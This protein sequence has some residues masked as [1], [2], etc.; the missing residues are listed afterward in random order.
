MD[1]RYGSVN[2]R[3]EGAIAPDP[4]VDRVVDSLVLQLERA[5]IVD[6]GADVLRVGEH[7]M[8]GRPCPLAPVLSVNAGAIE[9]LGD[10]AFS[11]IVRDKPSVDLL[12]YLD[13]RSG[14]GRRMTRS[15]CR[16]FRSPRPSSPLGARFRSI[17][18]RGRP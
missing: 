2:D 9:L 12:D 5:P 13:L 6:I 4:H 15:V 10:F 8:N 14:A 3:H 7:L 11:L 18:W 16:L 17:S 1:F